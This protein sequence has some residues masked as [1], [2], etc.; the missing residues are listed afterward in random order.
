MTRRLILASASPRRAELLRKLGVPFAVRPVDVDETVPDGMAPEEV[1]KE[2]AARKA[3]EALKELPSDSVILT[4]DTIVWA[5][6]RIF[7]KPR[8]K[9]EAYEM[10]SSISGTKHAVM[11]GVAVACGETG[12]FETDCAVTWLEM[13]PVPDEEIRE[14]VESGGGMDK[15]GGYGIQEEGDRFLRV[16]QGSYSNVVGLPLPLVAKMLR[17]FGFDCPRFPDDQ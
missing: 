8:D 13:V 10:L 17:A 16:L 5:S 4:A 14:Y 2:I 1:A 7:G 3:R 6:G 15:A 9:Q 12:W 11:T